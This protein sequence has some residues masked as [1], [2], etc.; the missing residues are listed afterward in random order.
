MM[1]IQP[2]AKPIYL[3]DLDMSAQYDRKRKSLNF[4]FFQIIDYG[5]HLLVI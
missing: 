1:E 2:E 5:D 4:Y 3:I